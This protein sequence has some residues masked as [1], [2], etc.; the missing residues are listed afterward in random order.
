MKY[1]LSAVLLAFLSS[2]GGG[3]GGSTAVPAPPS[4]VI[5]PLSTGLPY[6]EMTAGTYHTFD[7]YN[8]TAAH[9]DDSTKE[10]VV[11]AADK[12]TVQGHPYLVEQYSINT[13]ADYPNK[14]FFVNTYT[15]NDSGLPVDKIDFNSSLQNAVFNDQNGTAYLGEAING[16]GRADEGEPIL[17]TNPV[18]GEHIHQSSNWFAGC[19]SSTVIQT[20]FQTD[21]YTIKHV[22]SWNGFND[23]WLVSLIEQAQT[24]A[25][26]YYEYAYARNTPTQ[27]GGQVATWCWSANANHYSCGNMYVAR[28]S[29]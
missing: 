2:C 28:P 27:Q 10:L 18:A 9:W 24:S 13:C 20:G 8:I 17:S 23:V 4:P 15:F 5:Q 29:L 16:Y 11:D 21:Y 3:G 1:L 25:P 7:I 12:G 6:L 19:G 14:T 26:I 22:D